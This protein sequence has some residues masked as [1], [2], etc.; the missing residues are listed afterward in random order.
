MRVRQARGVQRGAV[1]FGA[2]AR[3]T[4]RRRAVARVV[5][6][7][8]DRGLDVGRLGAGSLRQAFAD[9][10]TANGGTI[11]IDTAVVT[12]IFVTSG[13]LDVHGHRRAHIQGNGALVHGN[14]SDA[15]IDAW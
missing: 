14:D 9:A 6:G 7:R 11:C 4:R 5:C 13:V 12:T 1:V 10:S 3:A 2:R 15:M 8:H